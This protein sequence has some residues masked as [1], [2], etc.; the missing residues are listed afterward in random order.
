MINTF[1]N[2]NESKEEKNAITFI[3]LML[4]CFVEEGKY[5][6]YANDRYQLIKDIHFWPAGLDPENFEIVDIK[7]DEVTVYSA[8]DWQEGMYVT[9]AM[10]NN[11]YIDEPGLS[12]VE[13]ISCDR[14]K[15]KF[16]RH[17]SIIKKWFKTH[18][19]K[20]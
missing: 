19:D 8:G 12:V 4:K 6:P 14:G 7:D 20:K 9:L 17:S 15:K 3:D 5:K 16:K 11:D 1:K 10:S 18:L 13:V 2:F